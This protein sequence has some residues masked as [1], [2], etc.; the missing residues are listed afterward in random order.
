MITMAPNAVNCKIARWI[1]KIRRKLFLRGLHMLLVKVI[2]RLICRS[3]DSMHFSLG[4]E[5]NT[6]Q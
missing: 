2:P 3:R 4:L 1:I 5:P 6:Y